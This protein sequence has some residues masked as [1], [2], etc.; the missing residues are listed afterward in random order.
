MPY[1]VFSKR[2]DTPPVVP[3]LKDTSTV[4]RTQRSVGHGIR[5]RYMPVAMQNKFDIA[6]V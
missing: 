3:L 4:Y 6:P 5:F 2:N 1:T